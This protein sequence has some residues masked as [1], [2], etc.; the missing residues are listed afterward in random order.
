MQYTLFEDICERTA[1]RSAGC[2]PGRDSIPGPADP[3]PV[4]VPGGGLPPLRQNRE[5]P[6]NRRSFT[7]DKILPYCYLIYEKKN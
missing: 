5:R 3:A 7:G 6:Q 4:H 1:E 2:H